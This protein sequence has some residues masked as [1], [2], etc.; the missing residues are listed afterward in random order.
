MRADSQATILFC[1][2][3]PKKLTLHTHS[4]DHP[5]NAISSSSS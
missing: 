1:P 2:T 3:A 4:V 5:A